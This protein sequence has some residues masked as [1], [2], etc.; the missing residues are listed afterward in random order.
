[1]IEISKFHAVGNSGSQI[2]SYRGYNAYVTAPNVELVH[3]LAQNTDAYFDGRTEYKT[4]KEYPPKKPELSAEKA[5]A[6]QELA[7]AISQALSLE[8]V[9]GVSAP[10]KTFKGHIGAL[11]L[12]PNFYPHSK[13]DV[14][15]CHKRI[16]S[17]KSAL[18]AIDS[19]DGDYSAE[20]N[21]S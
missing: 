3:T 19:S 8:L 16:E 15:K 20:G 2:P 21:W 13:S 5:L 9:C 12:Y 7:D 1:M 11:Q 10:K 14:A 17:A 18:R 4:S 6:L